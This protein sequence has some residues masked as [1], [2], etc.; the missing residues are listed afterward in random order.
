MPLSN[1]TTEKSLR[2]GTK[3]REVLFYH[4]YPVLIAIEFEPL[5]FYTCVYIYQHNGV[6]IIF[7]RYMD[8]LVIV[9]ASI[10]VIGKVKRKF[11][12]KF[13]VKNI[14]DVSLMLGMQVTRGR[15]NGKLTTS[16]EKYT[17]SI[18]NRFSMAGGNPDSIPGY[19]S[20]LS[21]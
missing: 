10:E 12:D 9:S 20:E 13:K 8:D 18:L 16:Q 11:M 4:I 7:T 2:A 19:C 1:E 14:G 21:T 5:K 6:I 15:E 17:K 3:P